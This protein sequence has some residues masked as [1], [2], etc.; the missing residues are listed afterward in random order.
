LRSVFL[1]A[2]DMKQSSLITALLLLL[3]IGSVGQTRT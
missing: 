2:E 3:N 1:G